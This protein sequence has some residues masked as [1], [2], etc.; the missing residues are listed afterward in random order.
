M[1]VWVCDVCVIPVAFYYG[2]VGSVA[3]NEPTVVRC[4][5]DEATVVPAAVK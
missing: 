5:I 3:V 2:T 1:S 4:A